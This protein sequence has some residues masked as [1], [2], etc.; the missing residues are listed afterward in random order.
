MRL[1]VLDP[2]PPSS[3][4]AFCSLLQD[5]PVLDILAF[6]CEREGRVMEGCTKGDPENTH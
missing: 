6:P 5:P 3:L 2:S 4:V 1:W